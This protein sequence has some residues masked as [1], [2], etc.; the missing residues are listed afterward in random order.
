MATV[1]WAERKNLLGGNDVGQVCVGRGVENLQRLITLLAEQGYA[2]HADSPQFYCNY[3]VGEYFLIN[4]YD[5]LGAEAAGRAWQELYLLAEE[6]QRPATEEEI[7]QA[8]LRN[9][10]TDHVAEF[11]SVYS[12]WHG[13]EIPN[14]GAE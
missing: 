7:Y 6:A 5:T 9:T 2:A 3:A 12:R 8:F 11:N 13:G 10:S 4:L 1:G 14:G